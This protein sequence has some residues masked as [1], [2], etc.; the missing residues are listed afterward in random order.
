MGANGLFKSVPMKA[1]F[2]PQCADRRTS[3]G[4]WRARA[5]GLRGERGATMVEFALIMVPFFAVLFG[6]FEVGFVFWGTY[7]LE[8]ATEEAARQIRTG[9]IKGNGGAAA[10]KTQVCSRVVLLS[11]CNED[12]RLDVRSFNSFAEIQNSPAQPL[13]ND[14]KLKDNFSFSPGGARSI[15]LVSTFYQ[16]PLI[17][18]ISSYSLSN[19]AGGDRLLS[20]SAAF[21]NEPFPE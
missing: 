1:G 13:D 5:G 7:E 15:V 3:L 19:M 6:I 18:A 12:L 20:A 21:R 2:T 4:R 10:F 16:W 9:Q 17:N 11:R 8:N 14:R